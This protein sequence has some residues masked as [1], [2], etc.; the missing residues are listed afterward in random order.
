MTGNFRAII[1]QYL[2]ALV[3]LEFVNKI[4][5]FCILKRYN[6]D[7]FGTFIVLVYVYSFCTEL[8]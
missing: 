7:E 5:V 1:L 4:L 3:D 6:Y 2:N 8:G